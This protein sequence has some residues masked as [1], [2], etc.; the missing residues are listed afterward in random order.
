MVCRARNMPCTAVGLARYP[1]PTINLPGLVTAAAMSPYDESTMDQT[2]H[3]ILTAADRLN[4]WE[5]PSDDNVDLWPLVDPLISELEAITG[6]KLDVD[7][8]VQDASFMTDV[9][10]LD[11]RYYDRTSGTG[12]IY[13]VFAFRF[14]N[15][16]R[17]FTLHGAEWEQRF[18]ELN[19]GQCL[20]LI[21]SRGFVY[22]AV[23]DLD[24]AYDGVNGADNPISGTPLT[25]WIRFFDYI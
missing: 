8:N 15:F 24:V 12:A 25:W 1:K 22:V 14:S 3:E 18:D 4:E 16:G 20:D 2:A 13:H 21:R 23:D 5:F 7:R 17:L 9:G 10:L 11:D 6:H 19:L